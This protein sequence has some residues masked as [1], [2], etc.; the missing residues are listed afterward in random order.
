LKHRWIFWLLIIAFVW[1]VVTRLTEI[2]KLA[3]TLAQGKWEW[4]LAA[5]LVQAV[6]F[7]VF[8]GSYQAAFS[9]VEVKSRLR[10][11]L[12]V[13]FGSLFVNVVVPVGVGG[14]AL[15]VDD[16][17]RRGESSA[18]ATAGLFVQL[19]ADYAAFAL[20]LISGMIYLLV[21]H[22]LKPYEIITSLLLLL[23]TLG[24][25]AI[26]IMG[27][28]QPELL[29]W[30]MNW[31][32]RLA[33]KIAG[34]LK[35]RPFLA[36][37]W[38][39]SKEEGFT[40]AAAAMFSHPAAL[41]KTLGLT[42]AAHLLDMLC[43]Y[44]LF[45][46]FYEPVGLGTLVAG[47]AM[48]IL[49]W[50]I[51]IT[52][53]GIGVVEGVMALVFTSLG[54]PAA[55]AA[56][57]A[58]AFRGLSFWLPLL[59]GFIILRKVKTFRADE[60]SVAEGWSV[61]IVAILTALMG[62]INVLSAVTPS[63]A[64]RLQVLEKI[65][66]FYVRYGGHL[67][68]ALAGFAL[69]LLASGLW[70]RKR[71]AWLLTLL[72]LSLSVISHLVKGLDYEEAVLA[73]GLA[74]WLVGLRHHF[75]A[76]SDLPSVLQGFKVL[77]AAWVFTL[78]YGI[79][80]FYLLDRHFKVMYGFKAALEQ[81]V[82]MFT[83]YYD[84]GLEPITGFGRY[85]ADSI[86]LIG[87]ITT[88]YA[89]LMLLRPVLLHQ[90]ATAKQRQKAEAIVTA[91]GRSSLARLALLDDKAY[92][93]S[94]AGS[95]IAYAVRQRVGL[96][97]GDPIGPSED[98][99]AAIRGFIDHC[100]TN[101]WIPAFYQV[102]PDFLAE[103]QKAGLDALCIGQEGIVVLS[104]FSIE[105]KSNK[106]LRSAANRLTRTGHRFEIYQPPL[107]EALLSELREVSDEWLTTMHGA[108]KRFSLGW[109]D[110]AYIRSGPVAVILNE[111]GR[112]HAF[113]NIVSEY[114][115][116][117]ITIDLMRHR[118]EI[119][120]GTMDYLFI[121]IIEW[122]REQGYA[123]FNLGLS[124][125]YGVGESP[126]SPFPERTLHFIYDHI[127]QFYDFKGLHEFKDKYHPQWSPRYIAYPGATS[128]A[129]VV[130]ATVE[131][132]SGEDG[133]LAGTLRKR[134]VLAADS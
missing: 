127:D 21:Q 49:F 42:L 65:S 33:N 55:Q 2:E 1:V 5:V 124:A 64:N 120:P 68:A 93:F 84:P 40:T 91:Y 95:V 44:V 18:R 117:E 100:R 107:G 86:Y 132:D 4:V 9:T 56:T 59:I 113:A 106:H 102:L 66:P 6:Y 26:L 134:R 17:A 109:F 82:V 97:L 28:W 83:R 24:L 63:L 25:T 79:L 73:G 92:Y 41:A 108:E 133:I 131:A 98:V 29:R 126:Q 15:F 27:L 81:T 16:A 99:P 7:I 101:D 35:R 130:L 50:V 45:L 36:E 38:A 114:Q 74:A 22:D 11:L 30:L 80:G 58:L 53:Q 104:D 77:I 54:V 111:E 70:R 51:S 10:D 14:A 90:P 34:W 118:R 61:R 37:D 129:A 32:Q 71:A 94:P 48:G 103:Y 85:F 12:P 125:L 105:G 119:E 62:L 52:P 72:V 88:S 78:S 116:N 87:A 3:N 122:A 128:L 69:L 19:I 60:R 43:L 8:T 112:I 89:I 110:N 31:F 23:L 20:I 46:A 115:A 39:T 76:R 96:A 13:L 123:T 75:H 47:Y 121:G 67:S 57:V